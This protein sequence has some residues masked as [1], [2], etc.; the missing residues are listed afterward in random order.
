MSRSSYVVGLSAALLL[1]ALTG[2]VTVEPDRPRT[3]A[4][5]GSGFL[6]EEFPSEEAP[7]T[8]DTYMDLLV[9]LSWDQQT[10]ADKQAMCDSIDLLG[11][12]WAEGVLEEAG[13]AYGTQGEVIDW[14]DAAQKVADKCVTEGYS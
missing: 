11:V 6:P 2:C 9:N 10:E 13:S 14:A 8:G 3:G 4:A 7:P 12:A 5:Q 1:A